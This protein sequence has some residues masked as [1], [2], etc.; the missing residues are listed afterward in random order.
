M[1]RS[2][3]FP[4]PADEP[5]SAP[6]ETFFNTRGYV[7]GGLIQ[8]RLGAPFDLA[9]APPFLR[10]L[11]VT[12]GTVTKSLEAFFW[13]PVAV[14]NLGQTPIRPADAPHGADALAW[15][16][17]RADESLLHRRVRLRGANS[18]VVYAYAESLL[19]LDGLPTGLRED[20]LTGRIGIG[21]LLRQQGLEAY[22]EIVDVGAREDESLAPVLELPRCGRL[23][24]RTYRVMM[25][26]EPSM[27]ITETFP[28]SRY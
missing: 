1:T 19:R 23:L 28:V 10:V 11:L 9:A 14:D 21:E 27:L 7:P 12:D 13:E 18:G 20:L 15:L 3:T 22:R 6:P 24:Y 8:S 25:R 17:P 5:A 26:G 4:T 16:G 2:P